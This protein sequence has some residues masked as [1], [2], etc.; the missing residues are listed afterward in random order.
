VVSPFKVPNDEEVFLQ[1]E[2]EKIKL[3]E[4]KQLTRG[5]KIWD[6]PTANTRSPLKRVTDSDIPPAEINDKTLS[7][8]YNSSQRGYISA[9]M[10]IA[11]SRVTFSL[12]P[13]ALPGGKNKQD[14]NDFITQKKEMFLV[15]LSQNV[16]KDRIEELDWKNKRKAKALQ[17]SAL[18]LQSDDVKLLKFIEKDQLQ[19][20]DREREADRATAE[21]KLMEITDKELQ[22]QI[23]N[24]RSDIEKS[25]DVV[26]GLYDHGQFLLSLSPPQWVQK[27]KQDHQKALEQF[28]KNWIREHKDDTREDHILFRGEDPIIFSAQGLQMMQNH[29]SMLSP[30][31]NSTNRANSRGNSGMREHRN[32]NKITETGEHEN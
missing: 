19:T 3:Q 10:N 12:E 32:T 25:K 7:F 6:K 8:N 11:K 31:V 15:E 21:R 1:R 29:N 18:Q 9:A 28:K 24:I 30:H 16:I 27:V 4:L 2:A 5:Q 26:A 17:D 14:I 20:H 22:S 23:V 13:I